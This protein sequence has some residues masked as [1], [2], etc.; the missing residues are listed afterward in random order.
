MYRVLFWLP[1]MLPMTAVAQAPTAVE[2][3]QA[4]DPPPVEAPQAAD[5]PPVETPQAADPPPV[6]TPQT[7]DL[8][9]VEA[10]TE[11]EAAPV[12]APAPATEADEPA[13]GHHGWKHGGAALRMSNGF[14]LS[15]DGYL[16]LEGATILPDRFF[17]IVL[18]SRYKRESGPNVGRNDGFGLGGARLNLRASYGDKLYV[19]LGFDGAVA[20]FD[21]EESPIG[22]YSTGLKDAYM[23]YTF[24]PYLVAY[25]GRFKPPFEVEELTSTE[26]QIFVH[27]SLESR[28]VL[29]HEGPHTDLFNQADV[30]GFAPGRQIGLMLGG[31]FGGSYGYA[32]AVTNGNSGDKTL[33]DND[34]LAA[35]ARVHGAWGGSGG[36]DDDEEGPAT[37]G[38][39][40]GVIVGLSSFYNPT[41]TGLPGSRLH[42][43][44]AGAGLDVAAKF[45]GFLLQVQVLAA[46]TSTVSRDAPAVLSF[47]GHVAAGVQIPGTGFFPAYRFALLD[48]Q[49]VT[50][51]DATAL[52]NDVDRV[53]H[54]TLGVRYRPGDMPMSL[55]LE[56]THSVEQAGRATHNDR[57]E[58]AMQVT[59][60]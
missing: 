47:G 13:K 27:R 14:S 25:A 36:G 3:P 57:V 22:E 1:L 20:T 12:E 55:H 45:S 49:F 7:A 5:P 48:P 18:P 33:I 8:P 59:F 15:L 50:D 6:E 54:H 42:D 19:R 31:D 41:S 40:D 35:W 11:V 9:P 21:E 10:V 26:N 38:V 16:R 32:L 2:A 56:Y 46:R 30:R 53:M 17:G 29:R 23:R 39:G 51:E 44:I 24:S 37:Y 60:K 4:A 34:R 43:R 52:T 28:G 58:V